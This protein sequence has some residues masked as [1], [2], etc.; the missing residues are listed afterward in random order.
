MAVLLND[1][2]NSD[3]IPGYEVKDSHR[4]LQRYGF[5]KEDV[6][7]L[8]G[9]IPTEEQMFTNVSITSSTEHTVVAS[10]DSNLYSAV[11]T[12]NFQSKVIYNDYIRVFSPGQHV[13]TTL[14]L[15]QV[16]S[17]RRHG[18]IKLK[19][20]AIDYDGSERAD[21]YYR[22]ARL[23]YQMTDRNDLEDFAAQ[24]LR[25]SRPEQTVG[26]LVL[27]ESGYTLWK[28][29]GQTWIGEFRLADDSPSMRHLL[30]Y[31]EIK[32]IDFVP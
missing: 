3:S 23:G 19:A 17:A 18:F 24:M 5:T 29:I 6:L 28:L 26:E 12:I 7:Q 14:F 9:G 20:T 2:G 25:L 11:R 15:R 4:V 10:V 22:W 27:S 32:G 1:I 8:C 30:E 16:L 21:G 13:G 31:L